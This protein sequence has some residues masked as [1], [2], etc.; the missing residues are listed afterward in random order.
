MAKIKSYQGFKI[1]SGYQKLTIWYFHSDTK[2]L[3]GKIE[4]KTGKKLSRR[5]RYDSIIQL[6][7]INELPAPQFEP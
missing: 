6:L 5:Q 3:T 2:Q 4:L 7:K 1:E